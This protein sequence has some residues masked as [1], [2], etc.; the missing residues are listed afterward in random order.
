VKT[1]YKYKL[2]ITD[3]Q[4]VWMPRGAKLLHVDTQR[5]TPCVWALVDT[6]NEE[7]GYSIW[8]VGTG[9]P[10]PD[11]EL[12]HVGSFQM[13]EALVWHVFGNKGG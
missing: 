12:D 11:R 9:N 3:Y 13:E 8:I 2:A 5:G 6:D 10:M 1:I 7:A 4:T